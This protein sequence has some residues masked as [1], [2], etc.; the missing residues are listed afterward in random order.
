MRV[1]KFYAVDRNAG[2]FIL[3]FHA[4]SVPNVTNSPY[5]NS[6]MMTDISP[7]PTDHFGAETVFRSVMSLGILW[8]PSVE[9]VAIQ[10]LP[11]IDRRAIAA[12]CL[13]SVDIFS[14]NARDF[15]LMQEM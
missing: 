11:A 4:Y 7:P 6:L 14:G 1:S 8:M 2:L 12:T 10:T 13:A 15:Q 5:E 9:E 3:N